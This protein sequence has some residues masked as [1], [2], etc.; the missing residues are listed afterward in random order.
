[1]TTYVCQQPAQL[2]EALHAITALA[3]RPDTDPEA[4]N[5]S[6]TYLI[7]L[8]DVEK[9][10]NVALGQYNLPLAL[11]IARRSQKDPKE[12]VPFLEGLA[13][14]DHDSVR[15]FRIDS[16]LS[17][18]GK[19]L[20]HYW[21]IIK[22]EGGPTEFTLEGY[23]EYMKQHDLFKE[24][25]D[26]VSAPSSRTLIYALFAE[27]QLATGNHVSAASL[28]HLAEDVPR[29]L[30]VCIEAGLWQQALSVSSV[31]AV[32]QKDKLHEG[33]LER[34]M[35]Q[36]KYQE[37]FNLA[38]RN[39]MNEAAF[40]AAVSGSL[41]LEA[42]TI[43]NVDKE[44]LLEEALKAADNIENEIDDIQ[45]IFTEKSARLLL[46]QRQI[47]NPPEPQGGALMD[48]SDS[49]SEMTFKTGGTRFTHASTTVSTIL[50][51]TS[52]HRNKKKAERKMMK[53]KPGS[54]FERDGLRLLLAEQ[55]E[56]V[57]RIHG[58]INP[59]LVLLS[60][61]GEMRTAAGI[62]KALLDLTT[63]VAM[64]CV[65]ARDLQQKIDMKMAKELS[66]APIPVDLLTPLVVSE[67]IVGRH[68]W[69]EAFKLSSEFMKNAWTLPYL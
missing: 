22:T 30:D 38:V 42:L 8:V 32:E 56:H 11:S 35:D 41:W 48:I 49:I 45:T 54:P 16:Y 29:A 67:E 31:L 26:M 27:A 50:S 14:L 39:A 2:D 61:N 62:Q 69:H 34:L 55:I 40:E 6:L 9:L 10:Y 13:E 68:A 20:R 66:T 18:H 28:Y 53:A 12:Y 36:R 7:F 52:T 23:L 17:R 65:Q 46:L 1:M 3:A 5:Q 33:L 24:A 47:V 64:F 21:D 51:G 58:S 44:V 63:F 60:E 19:A 25:L 4:L 37:A 15:R 59:L 57:K 43:P